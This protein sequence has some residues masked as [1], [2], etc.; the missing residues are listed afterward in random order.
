[1]MLMMVVQQSVGNDIHD[2]YGHYCDYDDDEGDFDDD[3]DAYDDNYDTMRF[4]E[5]TLD[6]VMMMMILK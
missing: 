1:M 4:L 2:D 5:M 3:V 6:L